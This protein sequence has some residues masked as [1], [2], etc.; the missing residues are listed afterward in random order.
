MNIKVGNW[1]I[2]NFKRAIVDTDK[3]IY[4]RINVTNENGEQEQPV[5]LDIENLPIVLIEE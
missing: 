2:R 4:I 3:G 1:E 5:L